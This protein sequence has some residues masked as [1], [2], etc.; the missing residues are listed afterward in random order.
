MCECSSCMY[1]YHI[2]VQCPQ[3]S[4][5]AIECPEIEIIAC[6]PE[7]NPGPLQDQRILLTT[8]LSFH[9][10]I[11]FFYFSIIPSFIK[12]LPCLYI[13]EQTCR[14]ISNS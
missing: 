2:Y 1:L 3:R 4:E 10:F 12:C 13:K 6:E 8:D 14:N 9:P 11:H 7:P 5:E